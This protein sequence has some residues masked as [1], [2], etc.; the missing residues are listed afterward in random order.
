LTDPVSHLAD[1]GR[2]ISQGVM[3]D[4]HF[5]ERDAA[6]DT[7]DVGGRSYRYRRHGEDRLDPFSGLHGHAKWLRLDDIVG[8]LRRVGFSTVE[9][10]ER[11][12]ERNGPRVLLFA[13]K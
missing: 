7:Y 1:L 12:D 6:T 5:A 3:V 9:I 2:W 11:R 8:V 10:V 4:T 13:E